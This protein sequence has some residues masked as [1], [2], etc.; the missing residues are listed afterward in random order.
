MHFEPDVESIAKAI[1][2]HALAP[3][4]LKYPEEMSAKSIPAKILPHSQMWAD[5]GQVHPTLAFSQVFAEKIMLCVAANHA[6]GWSRELDETEL[7][8]FSK[9]MGR[10][11]RKMARDIRQAQVKKT[12]WALKLFS[13]VADCLDSGATDEQENGEEEIEEEDGEPEGDEDV[14][15]DEPDPP[16][17]EDTPMLKRPSAADVPVSKVAKCPTAAAA[18][19]TASDF[20]YGFDWELSSAWREAAAGGMRNYAEAKLPDNHTPDGHPVAMFDEAHGCIEIKAL[21]N[22]E[23]QSKLSTALYRKGNLW[24]SEMPS[25]ARLR[26][27][28]RTDRQPLMSLYEQDSDGKD[29]Q[30]WMV[31]VGLFGDVKSETV[32]KQSQN[33]M[34]KIGMEYSAA[35]LQK[36]ALFSRRDALLLE[37]GIVVTSKKGGA[38][39]GSTTEGG[40]TK[41]G[42]TEKGGTTKGGTEKDG[43]TKKG[44]TTKGGTEK[45]GTTKGSGTTKGGG[46]EKVG[47]TAKAGGT[48]KTVKVNRCNPANLWCGVY[49]VYAVCSRCV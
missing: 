38:Q 45:G 13:M 39:Q 6:V 21:T 41:G 16:S 48:A 43:G 9:R 44:G 28:R 24:E 47:G 22:A 34:I 8:D 3:D 42:G 10:R 25:G 36:E 12:G 33:L 20:F 5:I 35:I 32:L 40:G 14:S 2:P 15:R 29:H 18:P 27:A 31:K 19:S 4:W 23:L 37:F 30:V 17:A 1:G 26:V 7:K 46:T 49:G 11:L